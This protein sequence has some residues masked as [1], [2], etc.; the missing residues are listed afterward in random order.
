MHN[1]HELR[2]PRPEPPNELKRWAVFQHDRGIRVRVRRLR[3]GEWR[4]DTFQRNWDG[5]HRFMVN[6]EWRWWWQPR[7]TAHQLA[8][9]TRRFTE[10]TVEWG[11]N[12]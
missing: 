7:M 4:A 10:A 6:D 5:R 3:T 1:L 2:P 8:A 9:L 12:T 11:V